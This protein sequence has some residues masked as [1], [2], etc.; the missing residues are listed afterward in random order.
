MFYFLFTN[1]NPNFEGMADTTIKSHTKENYLKALYHLTSG[2]GEVAVNE[3]ARHLDL[4]MPTVTSMMQK[5]ADEKLIRYERYKPVT[6]TEK[7][8]K[9]AGLVI[10]KHRLTEMF[11]V[12]KMNFG[13]EEVHDI[14]EQIEHIR[15]QAFFQK[16]DEMLGHP[17]TDP[18]G[19][20]I[21]DVSG[22]IKPQ[23]KRSLSDISPGQTVMLTGLANSAEEFLKFLNSHKI[24]LGIP[25]KVLSKE[26][27]DG[28]MTLLI[29]KKQITL[30]D[31]VCKQLLVS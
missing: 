8:K 16:M 1:I 17:T 31:L 21:P 6:L 22:K 18:H 19:S 29:H 25:I 11:L 23:D 24:S 10:R 15:S 12:E 26:S 3:L 30:S 28:S 4:K 5:L 27:F 14:A 2:K 7:G 20:P 13:W 9:E